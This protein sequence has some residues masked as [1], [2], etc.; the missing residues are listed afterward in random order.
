MSIKY[1][2][3]NYTP[4]IVETI[5]W[6]KFCCARV[7]VIRLLYCVQRV[8]TW[9]MITWHG[10][11]R[12]QYPVVYHQ[13]PCIGCLYFITRHCLGVGMIH[14]LVVCSYKVFAREELIIIFHLMAF[15]I[16]CIFLSRHTVAKWSTGYLL[17]TFLNCLLL[18]HLP[19]LNHFSLCSLGTVEW[20]VPP[21]AIRQNTCCIFL[22]CM[23]HCYIYIAPSSNSP[24]SWISFLCLMH[25]RTNDGETIAIAIIM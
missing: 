13:F 2:R 8:L 9:L 1:R 10:T 11:E 25:A 18:C 3:G 7:P 24:C 14:V 17:F 20:C 5:C 21:R 19:P 15:K 6:I 23:T 22:S 16:S 4:I 12:K